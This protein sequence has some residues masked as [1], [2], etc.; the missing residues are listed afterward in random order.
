MYDEENIKS[1]DICPECGG[2]AVIK[3]EDYG[4]NLI[5]QGLF[6]E[7]CQDWIMQTCYSKLSLDNTQY[8]LVILFIL[9]NIY[10]LAKLKKN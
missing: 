10:I 8:E 7:N 5:R 3:T 6:C 4:L 2:K 9:I 1:D